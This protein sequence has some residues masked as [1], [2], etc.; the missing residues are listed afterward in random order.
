MRTE[1]LT[2]SQPKVLT[3]T[4]GEARGLAA[5]GT[6]LASQKG[7]WGAADGDVDPADGRTI[8]RV[9]PV[10][11]DQW[12]VRVSD[13]VG[14]IAVDDLQLQVAPKIP[15]DHLLYLLTKGG[16]L[17]RLDEAPVQAAVSQSLWELVARAFVEAAERLLRLGLVRDYRELA[18]TLDAAAGRIE[19]LGTAHHYYAARL[20]LD[21]V[22]DDFSFDTPLNRGHPRGGPRSRREPT[23]PEAA[24]AAG[25][26]ARSPGSTALATCSPST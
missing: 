14:V 21:C 20:A 15:V 25:G 4:P 24:P 16:E 11:P 17:P 3:L 10:G 1:T 2:E 8:V 22:F 26:P 13:A 5:V 12:S 6:R 18:D 23:P 19:I 7:W 9:Q